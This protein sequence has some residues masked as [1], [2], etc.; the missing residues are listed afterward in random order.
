MYRAHISEVRHVTKYIGYVT[1]MN[2]SCP[3]PLHVERVRFEALPTPVA[4]CCSVWLQCV[5]VCSCSVL[6]CVAV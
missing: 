5:A 6:Q 1:Q 3:S 4:V 2:E